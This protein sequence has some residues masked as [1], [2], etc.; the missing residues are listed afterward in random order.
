MKDGDK[1]PSCGSILYEGIADGMIVCL[2][3]EFKVEIQG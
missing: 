1:C 3:C 2:D